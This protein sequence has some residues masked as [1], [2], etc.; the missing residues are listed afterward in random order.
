MMFSQ[1]FSIFLTIFFILAMEGSR[2]PIESRLDYLS[3]HNMYLILCESN[4]RS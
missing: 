4:S 3:G 2:Q 1:R